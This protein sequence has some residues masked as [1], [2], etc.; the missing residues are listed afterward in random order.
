VSRGELTSCSSDIAAN[1]PR[2]RDANSS[3]A[4]SG[5]AAFCHEPR[6]TIRAGAPERWPIVMR[7]VFV[8]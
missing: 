3:D 7:K 4:S 1:D 6:F 8:F 2:R 5:H